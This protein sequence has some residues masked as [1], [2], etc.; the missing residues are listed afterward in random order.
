[1]KEVMLAVVKPW[2]RITQ[3]ISF[4]KE[5]NGSVYVIGSNFV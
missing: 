2:L 4:E 5:E 1:M 3:G